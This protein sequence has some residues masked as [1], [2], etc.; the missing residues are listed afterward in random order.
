MSVIG[1]AAAPHIR[2]IDRAVTSKMSVQMVTDGTPAFS[3]W[4]PSCTLHA[5]QEPQL[6]MATTA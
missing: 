2:A 1:Y 6:P 5:L 4:I 3:A